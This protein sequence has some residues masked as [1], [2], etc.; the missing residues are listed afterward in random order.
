MSRQHK[1]QRNRARVVASSSDWQQ[2]AENQTLREAYTQL[3][4]SIH[5]AQASAEERSRA[6]GLPLDQTLDLRAAGRLLDQY[7][8]LVKYIEG[9][10]EREEAHKDA[11][12]RDLVTTKSNPTGSSRGDNAY[13]GL[14]GWTS[15]GG[16]NRNQPIGVHNAKQLREWAGDEW[17]DAAL[18]FL[19]EKVSR[20]DL[21]VLPLDERKPYNRQVLKDMPQLFDYPNELMDTWPMLLGMFTRDLLTLGQG[22]FTKNMQV[23]PRVPVGFYCED[24]ANIKIYPAWSGDPNEPRYLYQQGNSMLGNKVPLRNDEAMVVF[25]NPTSYRYGQ[26]PV[27]TLANTIQSDMAA[28][29]AAYHFQQ[30]K[31]PPNMIQVQGY[32]QQQVNALRSVYEQEVMGRRQILFL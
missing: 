25:Y 9:I 13:G 27:Q 26:G 11:L 3:V 10:R 15:G 28:S 14:G 7:P 29:E 2:L 23:R 12:S 18:N 24:A 31:P 19:A 8:Q 16:L 30:F 22:V 1:K 21:Q 5:L 6:T 32:T 4:Q 17:V 20:A